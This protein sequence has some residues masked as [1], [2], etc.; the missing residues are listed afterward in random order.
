M[1]NTHQTVTLSHPML[2]NDWHDALSEEQL[3]SEPNQLNVTLEPYGYRILY[4]K[5]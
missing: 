2:T 5:L 3:H 1:N 4:R